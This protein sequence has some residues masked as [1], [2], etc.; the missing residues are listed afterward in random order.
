[1]SELAQ[2]EGLIDRIYEAGLIPSLWPALL[3]EMGAAVGG[4]GLLE[5]DINPN[6]LREI[7][8]GQAT[9]VSDG[10]VTLSEEPGLGGEPDLKVL[11][12]YRMI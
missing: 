6:P 12:K 1:M 10:K 2:P 11:A 5:M 3:R 7:C 4:N 8:V 9:W